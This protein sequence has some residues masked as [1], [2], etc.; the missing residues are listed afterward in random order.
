MNLS[1][2]HKKKKL[3]ASRKVGDEL[4]LVPIKNNVADMNEIYTLSETAG[5]IWENLNEQS[6]ENEIIKNITSE[7]DIDE[8]T[9]RKDVNDFLENIKKII[10]THTDK[11]Q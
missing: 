9:A 3:F 4:I 11:Q 7:F 2:I 5:F 8:P 10:S 6:S 1:E